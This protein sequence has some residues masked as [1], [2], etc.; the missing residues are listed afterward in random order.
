[1]SR[2]IAKFRALVQHPARSDLIYYPKPGKEDP[3]VV[4]A[5]V[6]RYRRENGLPGF[7]EKLP[8]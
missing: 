5:E 4:V 8:R 1:M 7:R 6:E 3:D 2:V